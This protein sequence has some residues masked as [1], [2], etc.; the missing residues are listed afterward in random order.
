MVRT[1]FHRGK[2]LCFPRKPTY[3]RVFIYP[4]DPPVTFKP[5]GKLLIPE[6]LREEFICEGWGTLLAAGAGFFDKRGMWNPTDSRL[7]PGTRVLFDHWVPWRVIVPDHKGKK[8]AV[9]LCGVLDIW[10]VVE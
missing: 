1:P 5:E 2:K 9:V 8:H 4:D 10:A 3:D 7:V 6:Y